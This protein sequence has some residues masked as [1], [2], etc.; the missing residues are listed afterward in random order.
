MHNIAVYNN[1]LLY[2]TEA[3]R[4]LPSLYIVSIAQAH[5]HYNGALFSD[6]ASYSPPAVL[7]AGRERMVVTSRSSASRWDML[8]YSSFM[9][10]G[11]DTLS[12]PELS[13]DV[14]LI[15]E[16]SLSASCFF[17]DLIPFHICLASSQSWLRGLVLEDS[18]SGALFAR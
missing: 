15:L 12:S 9:Y 14:R 8:R 2:M 16:S 11:A 6:F 1:V 17:T 7:M 3:P 18:S 13:S 10:A 5:Y 4:V